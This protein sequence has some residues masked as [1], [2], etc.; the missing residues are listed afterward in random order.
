MIGKSKETNAKKFA[1]GKMTVELFAEKLGLFGILSLNFH[2]ILNINIFFV[3]MILFHLDH[4]CQFSHEILN[5]Y[6]SYKY[7][8]CKMLSTKSPLLSIRL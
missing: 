3:K 1:L 4:V 8:S 5:R 7:I 6:I 2:E